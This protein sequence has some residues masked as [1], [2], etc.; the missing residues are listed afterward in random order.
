MI[1]NSQ[2]KICRSVYGDQ[3]DSYSQ[4]AGRRR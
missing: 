1:A 2:E 3:I 4:V